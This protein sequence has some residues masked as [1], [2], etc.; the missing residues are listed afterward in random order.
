M[1]LKPWIKSAK[2]HKRLTGKE[3]TGK[4]LSFIYEEFHDTKEGQHIRAQ[5]RRGRQKYEEVNLTGGC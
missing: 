4:G 3:F 5:K 1:L 2:T